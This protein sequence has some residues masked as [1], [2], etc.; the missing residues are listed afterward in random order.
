M[1][2]IRGLMCTVL[3]SGFMLT[4]LADDSSSPFSCQAQANGLNSTNDIVQQNECPKGQEAWIELG[5]GRHDTFCMSSS[6]YQPKNAVTSV[7]ELNPQYWAEFA[8][9][10]HICKGT[11]DQCAVEMY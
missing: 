7:C 8:P 6:G 9:I 10:R 2:K 11:P 5:D 3:L 1:R 4:A